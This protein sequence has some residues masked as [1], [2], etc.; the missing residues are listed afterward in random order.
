MLAN[1]TRKKT[2]PK[3]AEGGRGWVRWWLIVDTFVLFFSFLGPSVHSGHPCAVTA[4]PR[5]RTAHQLMKRPA[6]KGME[7][8]V[9]AKKNH[10]KIK[11]H[12]I[13]EPK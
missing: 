4:Y 6:P 12:F 10:Q 8:S 9:T 11:Q 2:Q 3:R 1:T 13:K 7:V 5:L